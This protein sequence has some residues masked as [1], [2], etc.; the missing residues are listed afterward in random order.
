MAIGGSQ[1]AWLGDM[2]LDDTLLGIGAA[3]LFPAPPVAIGFLVNAEHCA[4]KVADAGKNM[5]KASSMYHEKRVFLETFFADSFFAVMDRFPKGGKGRGWVGELDLEALSALED[6]CKLR[7]ALPAWLEKVAASKPSTLHLVLSGPLLGRGREI[8]E[9]LRNGLAETTRVIIWTYAGSFNITHSSEEDIQSMRTFIESSPNHRVVETTLKSGSWLCEKPRP[10]WSDACPPGWTLEE[11]KKN[12]VGFDMSTDIQSVNVFFQEYSSPSSASSTPP[13]SKRGLKWILEQLSEGDGEGSSRIAKL[14]ADLELRS[15][16]TNLTKMVNPTSSSML[17]VREAL[18][19]EKQQEL[20]ASFKKAVEL[21]ESLQSSSGSSS[22][23]STAAALDAAKEAAQRYAELYQ[24]QH[25][26]FLESGCTEYFPKEKPFSGPRLDKRCILRCMA[27]GQLQGGPTADVLIVLA[28]L[29]HLKSL[30][31]TAVSNAMSW[32]DEGLPENTPVCCT[33]FSTPAASSGQVRKISPSDQA[34]LAQGL[35]ADTSA[36]FRLEKGSEKSPN[37]LQTDLAPGIVMSERAKKAL[38]P[39]VDAAAAAAVL[40]AR[41][42]QAASA[43]A[44][45]KGATSA[46]WG[47]AAR[48]TTEDLRGVTSIH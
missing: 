22:S 14:L 2:E 35:P 3:A 10:F 27:K 47:L 13:G 46:P 16:T 18:S 24:G 45:G 8:F 26:D 6:A 11:A 31:P 4:D 37:A 28:M 34:P 12:P 43:V 44:K 32:G 5:M 41:R 19:E 48:S 36:L 38:A 23:S 29:L 39:L 9:G 40:G 30:D 42:L 20:E 1:W 21:V 33:L 7:D 15:L 17:K 25:G